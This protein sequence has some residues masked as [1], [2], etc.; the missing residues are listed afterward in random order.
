MRNGQWQ[1]NQAQVAEK[2]EN[3]RNWELDNIIPV[4][5]ARADEFWA[6]LY[7]APEIPETERGRQHPHRQSPV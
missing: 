3:Q 5:E 2:F 1:K 4:F 7:S 6:D